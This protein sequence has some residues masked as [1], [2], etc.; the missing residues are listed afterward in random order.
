MQRRKEQDEQKKRSV[1]CP[2]SNVYVP[3]NV[4][5]LE[6]HLVQFRPYTHNVNS[7]GLVHRHPSPTSCRAEAEWL[8]R[9][10]TWFN[11]SAVTLHHFG[12]VTQK[13]CCMC[14]MRPLDVP[15]DR[16]RD[17]FS[18]F[19]HKSTVFSLDFIWGFQCSYCT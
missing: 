4:S 19:S 7:L 5:L 15:C 13:T 17:F 6:T 10:Y 3:G 18:F 16:V 8:V 1:S 14:R 12:A 9:D 2:Q 11:Q